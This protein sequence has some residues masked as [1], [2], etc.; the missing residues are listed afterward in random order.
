MDDPAG[1]LSVFSAKQYLL[2]ILSFVLSL[3]IAYKD[4]DSIFTSKK[5]GLAPIFKHL[6]TFAFLFGNSM[7]AVS[8]LAWS[9]SSPTA[10]INSL[11][12]EPL[13]GD[14]ASAFFIGFGLPMLLRSRVTEVGK[15]GEEILVGLEGIYRWIKD[16]VLVDLNRYSGREK[17]KHARVYA[18]DYHSNPGVEDLIEDLKEFVHNDLNFAED[19]DR[20][21]AFEAQFNNITSSVGSLDQATE[22]DL[23][24]VIRL[25][26]DTIGVKPTIQ[27]FGSRSTG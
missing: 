24:K 15:T 13:R 6:P 2:L 26:L 23:E 27:F 3:L 9:Y 20:T 8:L 21:S 1:V 22:R 11:I 25:V 5:I 16:K 7:L 10:A 19:E 12:P 4:I 14:I 17:M 18:H